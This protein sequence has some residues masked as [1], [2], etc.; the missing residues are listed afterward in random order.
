MQNN[1]YPVRDDLSG[2]LAQLIPVR[3]VLEAVIGQHGV[4]DDVGIQLQEASIVIPEVRVRR[5]TEDGVGKPALLQVS[6]CLEVGLSDLGDAGAALS[7]TAERERGVYD[8]ANACGLRGVDGVAVQ[9][10]AF[11]AHGRERHQEHHGRA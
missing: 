9:R 11:L 6:F 1:T 7:A 8:V 10:I 4:L 3:P 2:G 5:H